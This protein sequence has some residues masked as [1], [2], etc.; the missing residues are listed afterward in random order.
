MKRIQSIGKRWRK[1]WSFY[2]W[3]PQ[4]WGEV[5]TLGVQVWPW[6]YTRTLEWKIDSFLSGYEGRAEW[7]KRAGLIFKGLLNLETMSQM[8]R[9]LSQVVPFLETTLLEK[10]NIYLSLY[11]LY[12]PIGSPICHI[13]WKNEQIIWV[14]PLPYEFEIPKWWLLLGE[15]WEKVR[16]LCSQG[17][18]K[19]PQVTDEGLTLAR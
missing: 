6:A 8:A 15:V 5:M 7:L 13:C 4:K 11:P 16:S 2:S 14:F 18:P 3:R 1:W 12:C 10:I 9:S 17:F 19:D